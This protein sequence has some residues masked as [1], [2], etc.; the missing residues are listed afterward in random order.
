MRLT[1]IVFK[2]NFE[3]GGGACYELDAKVGSLMKFGHTVTVVT[4]FSSQ[5]KIPDGLPYKIIQE[6]AQTTHLFDI[7][8][9]VCHILR[10]HQDET[11]VFHVDG[12]FGYGSGWY[13]RSGGKKPVLVHF[14]RELSSFPES[15]RKT[16][17]SPPFSLKNKLRFVFE[18]LF[19][20]PLMNHNNLFTFTSP[21]L[22][23]LYIKYGVRRDKTAVVP[24]FFDSQ[25]L[26]KNIDPSEI[27]KLRSEQKKQWTILCGGRLISEKGF[28]IIVHALKYLKQPERFKLIITGSGPE[29]EN[30]KKLVKELKVESLVNFTGWLTKEEVY[31]LFLQ[32]DFFVIPRWRPE[33][34]SMLALE[35]MALMVPYIVTENTAIAW[36][37]GDSALTFEDEDY[38][39]LAEQIALLA[40]NSELRIRLINKGLHRLGKLNSQVIAPQLEKLLLK[41]KC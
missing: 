26:Q 37:A 20:F 29:E 10:Q 7:Q 25:E 41:C 16:I 40:D 8:K 32:A 12:Q 1:F 15:T 5:N 34:T 36:Q 2:L 3:A 35:A 18:R 14:N 39:Q 31:K 30:L 17:V 22:Q 11:D 27:I 23:E 4:L 13:C 24:D 33:L 6:Q 28:D 9:T 38:Q 19:G 21:I